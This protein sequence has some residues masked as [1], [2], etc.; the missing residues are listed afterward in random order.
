VCYG[1]SL[2]TCMWDCEAVHKQLVAE[3]AVC[4]CQEKLVAV[5]GQVAARVARVVGTDCG[6][7]RKQEKSGGFRLLRK[8]KLKQMWLIVWVA[9]FRDGHLRHSTAQVIL[10]SAKTIIRRNHWHVSLIKCR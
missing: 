2:T 5:E 8:L 1:G 9:K 3:L 10:T 6:W 7:R 4:C